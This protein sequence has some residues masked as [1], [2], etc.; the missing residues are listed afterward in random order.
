MK[1]TVLGSGTAIPTKHRSSSAYVLETNGVHIL[2]DCGPGTV[3][4]LLEHGYGLDGINHIFLTHTHPD[5]V[6]DLVPLL[7]S[8]HLMAVYAEQMRTESPMNELPIDIVGPPGFGPKIEAIAQA[9][10]WH[11]QH[12]KFTVQFNEVANGDFTRAGLAVRTIQTEQGDEKVPPSIA[13]LFQQNGK[14]ILITG[15]LRGVDEVI[16]LAKSSFT[17]EGDGIDLLI[18][19]CA[20]PTDMP[21]G[22]HLNPPLVARAATEMN[23]RKVIIT[24]VYD[25]I[26]ELEDPAQAVKS[27]YRGDVQLAHDGLKLE[28]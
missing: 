11:V 24:H 16:A 9:M 20:N 15:D 27:A 12:E 3:R 1:L 26:V 7:L 19:E 18:I 28:V 8:K 21:R 14:R 2:I 4:R 10:H 25:F 13:Y 17:Q 23:A 22:T 6:S 5:H